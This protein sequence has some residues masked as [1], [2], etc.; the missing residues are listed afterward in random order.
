MSFGAINPG[1]VMP[2][3]G[4]SE[5]TKCGQTAPIM[6]PLP[7]S[8]P[9]PHPPCA[10]GEVPR[11]QDMLDRVLGERIKVEGGEGEGG[12]QRRQVGGG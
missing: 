5:T 1:P 7:S 8:S 2:G 3:R 4:C 12:S 10:Q 11:A 9:H 6:T